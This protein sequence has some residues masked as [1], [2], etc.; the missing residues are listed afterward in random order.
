M[1]I[2]E[3]G[4][5]NKADYN[6]QYSYLDLHTRFRNVNFSARFF[7][8]YWCME[9]DDIFGYDKLVASEKATLQKGMNYRVG[10]GLLDVSN[11][12]AR[13]RAVRG[14]A[15]ELTGMVTYRS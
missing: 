3:P 10:Q 12:V 11:F 6:L 7:E 9:V 1:R 8:V 4:R 13:E 15:D 5:W 14:R 2:P